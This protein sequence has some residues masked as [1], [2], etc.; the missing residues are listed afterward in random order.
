VTKL[1]DTK[2]YIKNVSFNQAN[3]VVAILVGLFMSP[4]IVHMLGDAQYGYWSL[5][6]SVT[7]YA[8]Y[9]DLGIHSGVN[10]YVT[11]HLAEKDEVRL[12]EKFNS[13]LIVLLAIGA[14]VITASFLLA[15][16]LPSLLNIPDAARAPFQTAFVLVGLVTATKFPFAAFH[17]VLIGAQR[18]DLNSGTALVVRIINAIIVFYALTAKQHL[19]VLA[20]VVASTQMLEGIVQTLLALRVVPQIRIRLLH[21]QGRAFAELFHFG[22][23][24][25]IVN[26]FSQFGP[27]FSVI[28]IQ[29]QLA[30]AAVTYFTI[31]L[32]I[33]PYMSGVVYAVSL[34]LLQILIPMDVNSD[35]ASLRTMFL[36]GSRYLAALT[37][38]LVANLVLVGPAFLGRWMGSKYIDPE[39]FGSSGVVLV[40]LTLAS[41]QTLLATV[42]QTVL[43]SRRKNKIFAAIVVIETIASVALSLW[44][45]RIWGIIGVAIAALVPTLITETIVLN[46][47]AAR[48][49]DTTF[50]KFFHE[51]MLPNLLVLTIV[52][53]VGGLA[54]H[55]AP[56]TG[57]ITILLSFTIVSILY[58]TLTVVIVIERPHRRLLFQQL[59]QLVVKV[60]R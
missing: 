10:Y 16:V 28:I 52:C 34:P 37:G 53:A 12:N 21:F 13:A 55:F 46:A 11:R 50:G 9:F 1:F 54:L 3:F 2:R 60:R 57:W 30:A 39:P 24:N 26:V 18:Y 25:F 58:L 6:V 32:D 23:F 5:V 27:V 22:I 45:V 19:V 17:A 31:S 43:L 40:I 8:G 15:A 56:P 44:L 29:R 48:H 33:I 20:I 47:I 38:L 51:A 59:A 7:A 14:A 36:T 35:I 41:A 4:F 42:G 49:A